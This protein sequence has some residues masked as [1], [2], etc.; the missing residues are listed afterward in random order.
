MKNLPIEDILS[1]IIQLSAESYSEDDWGL[2][3]NVQLH[4]SVSLW[5]LFLVFWYTLVSKMDYSLEFELLGK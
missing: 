3:S 4:F 1:I 5:S 2:D